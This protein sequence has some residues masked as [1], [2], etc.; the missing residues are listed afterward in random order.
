MKSNG[1]LQHKKGCK[2]TENNFGMNNLAV[3]FAPQNKNMKKIITTLSIVA[4]AATAVKAQEA[5]SSKAYA[6]VGVG[7][8]FPNAGD[9]YLQNETYSFLSHTQEVKKYSFGAGANVMV[10]GGFWFTK[11]VG[12]E[13]GVNIGGA[14]KKFKGTYSDPATSGTSTMYAKMPVYIMPSVVLQTGGEK[15]NVYSRLGLAVNVSGKIMSEHK[16][17]N[18]EVIQEAHF[19]TGVGFQG[20]L[21][22]TIPAGQ[23]MSIFIEANGMAMN[24]YLKKSEYTKYVVGG[25]NKL[26][27]MTTADKVYEYEN[28]VTVTTAQ[29]PSQPSKAMT[30]SLPFSNIGVSAGVVFKF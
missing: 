6:R 28:S 3:T 19:K 23:K 24:Q 26:A 17:G 12:V 8:A 10:A 11:N 20:A 5:Q 1:S 25:T 27:V 4:I 29:D 9:S 16:S 13:L 30:T 2:G 21:G 18:D 22:V 15:I 7:Y 14:P